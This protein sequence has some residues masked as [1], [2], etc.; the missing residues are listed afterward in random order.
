VASTPTRTLAAGAR[1]LLLRLNR[2][3]WPTKLDLQTHPLA[4]L[5]TTT[6]KE[7]VGGPEHG[8]VRSNTVSTGLTVLPRTPFLTGSGFRP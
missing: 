8:G 6:V 1:K 3:E 4:P 7:S 2:H 5:P